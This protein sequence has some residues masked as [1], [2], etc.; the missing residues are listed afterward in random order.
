VSDITTLQDI[1]SSGADVAMVAFA[2]FLWKI[3]RRL[4]A[5][6]LQMKSLWKQFTTMIEGKD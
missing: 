6:E 1:L 3:D 5:V 4:L 2:F